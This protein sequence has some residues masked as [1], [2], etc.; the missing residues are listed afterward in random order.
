MSLTFDWVTTHRLAR[1]PVGSMNDPAIL[2][3]AI[4]DCLPVRPAWQARAACRGMNPEIFY[5]SRGQLLNDARAVCARC[6]V[7]DECREWA[8]DRVERFGIWG[9]LSE[10]D[11]RGLRR[12]RRAAS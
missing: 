1:Q 6:P 7:R 5:P 11:R 9:G 8:L 3:D 4:L 10:H 2:A 12:Q